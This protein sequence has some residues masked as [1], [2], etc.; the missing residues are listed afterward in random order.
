MA[1]CDEFT[2]I[3]RYLRPLA[4]EGAFGLIDDAACLEPVAGYDQVLTS[5]TIACGIHY[6]EDDPP[7][8]IARK[9]LRVNLSDLASKGAEPAAYMLN[10]ALG[11][12]VDD[13]WLE[14]F[15]AGLAD[16]QKLFSIAM[17]GGDTISLKSG[18]V[19]TVTAIG[20]VPCGRM[21]HRFTAE[22]G[23]ALYLT[24]EIGAAAAGLALLT[25]PASPFQGLDAGAR[26]ACIERYRV[27][28]PRVG[29]ASAL[30]DHARSAMDISDGLVGDADKMASASGCTATINLERVVLGPGLDRPDL[31]DQAAMLIT[32]GD[33]YEI[34]ASVAPEKE[35]AF[36]DA[37][38]AA[39][40]GANRIGTLAPGQGPVQVMRS[41]H[42]MALGNR[43][44]Y[45]HRNS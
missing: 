17:L 39:G 25:D 36:A 2:L 9:A 45:V 20:L 22:A 30:R 19:I 11:P 43:R 6:L 13:A 4:G 37:A 18:S 42:P 27:P 41:G 21:V 34:L 31:S 28:Q 29:L 35:Q 23:D 7:D 44:A 33:D 12:E 5:D 40:I 10:L 14:G 3:E 15:V 16:D 38:S 32:G 24:G 1:R 8:T 26:Q